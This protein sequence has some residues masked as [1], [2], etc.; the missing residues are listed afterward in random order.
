MTARRSLLRRVLP[1]VA[2]FLGAGALVVATARAK[3]HVP[4]P[5]AP[6]APRAEN[7]QVATFAL[8]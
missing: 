2:G 8:G 5:L 4:V 3:E 7:V 6:D 1:A